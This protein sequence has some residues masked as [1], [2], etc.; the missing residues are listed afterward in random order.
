[1]AAPHLA[2]GKDASKSHS[3]ELNGKAHSISNGFNDFRF[4]RSALAKP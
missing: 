3:A 1:M 2:I 4:R